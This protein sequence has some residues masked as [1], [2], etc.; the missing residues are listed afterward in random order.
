MR[1]WKKIGIPVVAG[2]VVA[3]I[4]RLGGLLGKVVLWV[5]SGLSW[6]WELLYSSHPVPGGVILVLS[7]LALFGLLIFGSRFK[8][9]SQGE[10]KAAVPAFRNYTEDMID[11]V[12]WR[13][14]WRGNRVADL[15][16][17]CPTC[18]AQLVHAGGFSETQLICERCPSDGTFYPYGCRGRVVA[19][20]RGGD[21]HYAVAAA[22][23]E[24]IRRIRTRER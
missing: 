12:R 17:F 10:K 15:W 4:L 21:R 18:D 1:T 19:T 14:S 5:W 13:W 3:G 2:L 9:L 23:R 24:I 8:G 16:C 7:L 6:I 11:G 20:V 22:E